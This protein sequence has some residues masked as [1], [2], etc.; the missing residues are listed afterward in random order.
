VLPNAFSARFVPACVLVIE[1]LSAACGTPSGGL[2]A[3]DADVDDID[4]GAHGRDARVADAPGQP[5]AATLDAPVGG[6]TGARGVVA[7]YS[8]FDPAATCSA[9][10]HCC[11]SNYSAQHDGS[12][13]VAACSWGTIDCDGP[14]DCGSDQHCCADVIMD[15]VDGITGYRLACRASACG[16]APAHQELCHP[17]ASAAGTCAS[18][19]ACVA[20]ADHDF[21]LPS[22]L[23]ICQ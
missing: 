17:G 14:E 4:R 15:P 22:T 1:L 3:A 8:A 16:A 23:Y 7:C 21:D 13:E 6:G 10:S 20:A 18:G 19:T 12:C 5:D 2:V 9:P 11:F